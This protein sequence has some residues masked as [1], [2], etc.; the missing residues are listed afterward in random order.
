MAL[1]IWQRTIVDNAGN[2]IPDAEIEVFLAGT[3]TNVD[4]FSDD[5]GDTALANPFNAGPTGGLAEGFARFYVA[6]GSYD[7]KA[8]GGSDTITWLNVQIG[9]LTQPYA[10]RAAAVAANVPAVAQRIS[11]L[12]ADGDYL[13]GFIRAPSG[14]TGEVALTTNSGSDD[15]IP[16][17]DPTP[18][19]W[20]ESEVG[21]DKTAALQAAID[22]AFEQGRDPIIPYGQWETTG[23]KIYGIWSDDNQGQTVSGRATHLKFRGGASL[24]MTASSGFVIRTAQDPDTDAFTDEVYGGV[25]EYPII[26]MDSNGDAG[27]LLEA[28]HHFDVIKPD[29]RNVPAG[30]FD[31]DDGHASGSQTYPK[32]G[33]GIKGIT[34]IAGAYNNEIVDPF[35]RG[36]D[37]VKGNTGIWFGTTE[38]QSSQIANL[39]SVRRGNITNF[40]TGIRIDR[41]FNITIEFPNVFECTNAIV[42]GH[43]RSLTIKPYM[44]NCTNGWVT[45]AGTNAN[46]M[47]GIASV[48][49]TTNPIVDVGEDSQ[50]PIENNFPRYVQVNSNGGASNQA[51]PSDGAYHAI[52]FDNEVFDH[53][54]LGDLTGNTGFTIDSNG[55]G[56]GLY[57]VV[58][59][60]F[61]SYAAAGD[62]WRIAVYKNGTLVQPEARWV[63]ADTNDVVISVQNYVYLE[64]DDTVTLRVRQDSGSA[65]NAVAGERTSLT[66]VKQLTAI[67]TPLNR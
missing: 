30:T 14:Y 57:H 15:W 17:G 21:T 36:A 67:N 42:C 53:G 64:K 39:N 28:A 48:A 24:K 25:I 35:L 60:A 8:T 51:I 27:I 62:E 58:G 5:D 1:N 52:T 2:V 54:N 18:V 45:E 40:E 56:E 50:F 4:I 37:G 63:G 13:V 38:G 41:G 55:D 29:I 44:E 47:L 65:R 61:V 3:T 66:G 31:Y 16:E 32:M 46:V 6:Q 22:F 26:D 10:S 43:S 34:G 49:G 19:H 23:V 33:I 59:T 11:Y 20:A 9:D 7:I 12:N